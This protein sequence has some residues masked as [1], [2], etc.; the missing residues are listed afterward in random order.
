MRLTPSVQN[1]VIAPPS[2]LTSPAD[3]G[4]PQFPDLLQLMRNNLVQILLTLLAGLMLA[5]LYLMLA[6]PAYTA[7]SSIYIDPRQRNNPEKETQSSGPGDT[8]WFESQV[9]IIGSDTILR[10]V[11][12]KENLLADQEFVPERRTSFLSSLRDKIAPRAAEPDAMSLALVSL[13]RKLRV[14]RALNTYVVNVEVASN[15]P[16]KAAALASSIANAYL[17]DQASS[18]SEDARKANALIDARL[19]ELRSQVSLAES[20]VDEFKRDNKIVVSEGGLLNEQQLTKL[21]TELVAVRSQ[22]ATSRAKLDE[23]QSTLKRGVSP[24]SLPEAMSS[25][26]VQR[27]R[28]Q[29]AAAVRREASL[30]SQLQPRHPVMTD[31]RAQVGSLRGQINAELQRITQS[32]QSEYQ[33]AASREREIARE[34]KNAEEGVS[35]TNTAQIRLRAFER[36]AEASREVLR[37]FLSRAKETQELQNITVADARIITPAAVPPRPSS[38]NPWLILALATL[39]SLGLSLG[40]ALLSGMSAA[41][42]V[43]RIPVSGPVATSSSQTLVPVPAPRA[44]LEQF[45]LIPMIEPRNPVGRVIRRIRGRSAGSGPVT[46]GDLMGALAE[47]RRDSDTAYRDAILRLL[48]RV[49]SAAPANKTQVVLM[50]SGRSGMGASGTALSMSY[51]AA[52]Q[53]E[54]TLLV[55][56]A[57][58]DASLSNVFAAYID[59]NQPCSLDSKKDLAALTSRDNNSGLSFLPIALADLRLL[60]LAQRQRLQEGLKKLAADFDFVVIDAGPVLEDISAMALAPI[61]DTIIVVD[62]MGANLASHTIDALESTSARPAGIVRTLA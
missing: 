50:I 39:G 36:E 21:N 17:Q 54:R 52:L 9:S 15:S 26:V 4:G 43:H 30:S 56:A 44:E 61:A 33:I 41:A 16:V 59:Q 19:G 60:K 40:R 31:I 1:S 2:R 53:N 57:S 34:L 51:A 6:A 10:R 27:L 22:V 23:M 12:D 58:H 28:D 55:D 46:Y 37:S 24:E 7:T 42:P 3:D 62:A 18:K 20:R 49:R 32:T 13:A 45:G 25:P 8:T 29:F 5:T 11:I 35:K 38:P 14:R 47:G 48:M